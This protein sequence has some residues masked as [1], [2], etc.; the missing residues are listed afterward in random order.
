MALSARDAQVVVLARQGPD[1]SWLH[2]F[3]KNAAF[4][5]LQILDC[6]LWTV[7]ALGHLDDDR[8]VHE[9]A[10]PHCHFAEAE[11]EHQ[12]EKENWKDSPEWPRKCNLQ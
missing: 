1:E 10:W 3:D 9:V 2:S 11:V 7:I 12:G 4:G 8:P 5:Q 6:V